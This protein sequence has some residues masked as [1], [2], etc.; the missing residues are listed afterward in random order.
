MPG[1][2]LVDPGGAWGKR[3]LKRIVLQGEMLGCWIIIWI[4]VVYNW[5]LQYGTYYTD[6][7]HIS[8]YPE[9][10]MTHI[11]WNNLTR[12]NGGRQP[13]QKPEVSCI[14][15]DH[16]SPH[17]S[18]YWQLPTPWQPPSQQFHFREKMLREK[19]SYFEADHTSTNLWNNLD[20]QKNRN[21]DPP[22]DVIRQKDGGSTRYG[23]LTSWWLNQLSW[24]IWVEMGMFPK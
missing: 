8:T 15:F 7:Y 10:K 6:L 9:P 3:Y 11:S 20:P 1:W 19:T 17:P 18:S 5:I 24:K 22:K 21:D 12:K 16:T 14:F 13:H 2:W 23:L 4:M